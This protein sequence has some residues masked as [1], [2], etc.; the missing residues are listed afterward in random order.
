MGRYPCE[1]SEELILRTMRENDMSYLEA[2]SKLDEEE[3]DRM[4]KEAEMEEA[5]WNHDNDPYDPFSDMVYD[6]EYGWEPM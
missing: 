6:Y 5:L 3:I 1:Y 4:L 2:L